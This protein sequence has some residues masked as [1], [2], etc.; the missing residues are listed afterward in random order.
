[1]R[2]VLEVLRYVTVTRYQKMQILREAVSYLQL[3]SK[4]HMGKVLVVGQMQGKYL[5][6][7]YKR[8]LQNCSNSL[9]PSRALDR[10]FCRGSRALRMSNFKGPKHIL[11]VPPWNYISWNLEGSLGP[12]DKF[13]KGPIGFSGVRGLQVLAPSEPWPNHRHHTWLVVW[14]W[15]P[16]TE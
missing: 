11:N 8:F 1:M 16:D 3:V 15:W 7:A 6:T 9:A 2:L 5:Y 13:H 4:Q 14:L 12:L 10:H